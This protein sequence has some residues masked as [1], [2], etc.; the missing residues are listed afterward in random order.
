MSG[1]VPC[2][3]LT[4]MKKQTIVEIIAFLF[5][6]LF[7]YTGVGK[8]MDYDIAKEQ[9]S[10][11]PLLAPIA[12]AVVIF[13]PVAEIITSIL[14]F[15]PKTRIYGLRASLALMLAF[16]GY[17][18]YLLNYN[19]QLPCTCGGVLEQLSWPQHLI[20]NG[21]LIILAIT[22]LRLSRGASKPTGPK[23]SLQP[24]I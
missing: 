15:F 4:N 21:V 8:L 20:L 18:V 6:I 11:T 13:I 19:D 14:L 5:V 23:S 2:L 12:G 3:Q 1:I 16:T 9:I 17:I 10:L 22:A 24:Q 7:L